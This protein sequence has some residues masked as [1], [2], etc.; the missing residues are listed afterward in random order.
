MSLH[1]IECAL[2]AARQQVFSDDD[3]VAAQAVRDVQRLLAQLTSHPDEVARRARLK[4][5]RDEALLFR[6]M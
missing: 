6:F 5:K 1:E 3:A 2:Y 4:A